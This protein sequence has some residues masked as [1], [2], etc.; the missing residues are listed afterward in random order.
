MK[1]TIDLY[2]F[3]KEFEDYDRAD[4]FSYAA[5]DALYDYFEELE[6]ET[7]EQIELDVIG[8]CCDYHEYASL[9]EF[10]EEQGYTEEDYPDMDSL[11]EY[12]TVIEFDGGF[13]IQDF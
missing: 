11:R 3:R 8:I 13:V 1:K 12:T 6:D 9:Q 10:R 2:E 5:L 4:N 7:G